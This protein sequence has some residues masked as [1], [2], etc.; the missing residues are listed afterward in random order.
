MAG[1]EESLRRILETVPGSLRLTDEQRRE[2]I[3][4]LDDSVEAKTSAGTPEVEAVAQAFVEL[5]DVRKIA[6]RFP[7]PPLLST[8]EG[9]R[10]VAAS[11]AR[12]WTAFGLLMFFMTAEFAITS[13]FAAIFRTVKVRIPL[14]SEFFIGISDGLMDGFL[15]KLLIAGAGLAMV[16]YA[17]PRTRAP[18]AVSYGLLGVAWS[19]CIGLF[20]A[21]SLPLL[22]LLQGIGMRRT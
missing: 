17:L 20:V 10:V 7:P 22:S 2:I 9:I 19:L 4:H 11:R 5:G 15:V 13:R 1:R 6:R 12:A 21:L 18:R 14:L 16:I 3:A 8:P